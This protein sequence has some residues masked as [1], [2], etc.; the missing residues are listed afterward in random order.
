M[1]V[2]HVYLPVFTS[3]Y[4]LLLIVAFKLMGGLFSCN[5]FLINKQLSWTA[6]LS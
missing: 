2:Y 4:I 3:L 6:F 5:R 1:Y